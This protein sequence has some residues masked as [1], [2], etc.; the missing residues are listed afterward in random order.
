VSL[1]HNKDLA[2]RAIGLWTTGSKDRIEEILAP[3][4]VNHQHHDRDDAKV[5]RGLEAW[6]KFILEFHQAFPDFQ[7]TIEQ[8]IAEGDRVATRFTSRGTQKGEI[9][10]IAPTGRQAV[11]TGI[12]ID[13]I[14]DGR[15]VES[16]ANW[17]LLGML[18][19]L[20]AVSSPK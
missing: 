1:S 14:A 20:G 10:G 15:I 7:D 13:R 12:T 19:Q 9:M 18:Q 16:W 5:I 11:W 2:R 3:D 8:Q 17:D 6:K 4:Y